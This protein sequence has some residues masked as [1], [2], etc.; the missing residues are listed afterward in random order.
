MLVMVGDKN[1]MSIKNAK[2]MKV[3]TIGSL[4]QLLN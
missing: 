4:S 1:N 2:N 3:T